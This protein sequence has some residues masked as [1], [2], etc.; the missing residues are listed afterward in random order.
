[1]SDRIAAAERTQGAILSRLVPL[2]LLIFIDA[3]GF[4][5]IAPILAAHPLSRVPAVQAILYGVAIGIYPLATFFAAPILGALSDQIGRLPVML[6]CGTGLIVSY[7]AIAL[8]LALGAASIVILGRLV[9]GLTAATQAVALAALGDAGE[10]AGRDGRLNAGLFA[11]SLGF[12]CG[13]ALSGSLSGIGS[14]ADQVA[15]LAAIVLLAAVT[16]VWLKASHPAAPRRMSGAAVSL[17]ESCRRSIRDLG[18]SV[19]APR[20]RRLSLIFLL[21][22][23]GWG[24]FFFFIA[25]LLLARLE[26]SGRAASFYMAL[27][28]IGFCLS[29]A[30]A[31]PLLRRFFPVRAIAVAGM[32]VTTLGVGAAALARQPAAQW[33]LALPVATA[34]AAAYGAIIMLFTREAAQNQGEILGVTASINALAF[35]LTSIASGVIAALGATAPIVCA[36]IL[37]AGATVLLVINPAS[38]EG[39]TS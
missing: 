2:C 37:M 23:L 30:I 24:A 22:Q 6:L 12:V 7:A 34:V 1:M 15:P 10:S 33:L 28:G 31:M 20:L 18:R 19:A 8:G 13:P 25:P 27:L 26:F 5:M 38:N 36:A 39:A 3:M 9:G 32:G 35:G 14:F 4:A 16:L 17:P 29:F 21:Q 11:S